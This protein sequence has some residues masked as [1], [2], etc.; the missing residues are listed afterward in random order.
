MYIACRE[1]NQGRTLKEMCGQ[2]DVPKKELGKIFKQVRTSSVSLSLSPCLPPSL[3]LSRPTTPSRRTHAHAC[4]LERVCVR[5]HTILYAEE[6]ARQDLQAGAR[7]MV[8]NLEVT[9]RGGGFGGHM[10]QNLE[11]TIRGENYRLYVTI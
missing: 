6:G 10:V 4:P 7:A 9:M 5:A 2:T 8:Q 1:E 3:S 11:V